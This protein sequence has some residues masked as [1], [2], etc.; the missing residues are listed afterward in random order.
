M[1]KR[2]LHARKLQQEGA[3][4]DAEAILRDVLQVDPCHVDALNLMGYVY[5]ARND[6]E[7]AELMMMRA[8]TFQ[9]R[10]PPN[11]ASL[12]DL[13]R[14]LGQEDLAIA[15]YRNGLEVDDTY[16]P[17]LRGLFMASLSSGKKAEAARV[18]GKLLELDPDDFQ[19]LHNVGAVNLSLAE[20]DLAI[21]NLSR[22]LEIK[23]DLSTREM[24]GRSY[25]LKG[26][27]E[28]AFRQYQ[29]ILEQDPNHAIAAHHLAANSGG[30]KSV[31]DRAADEYVR[32]AFD[33]F[34]KHFD[35]TLGD[36]RYQAPRIVRHMMDERLQEPA[37]QYDVLDLGCG[38]GLCGVE[39]APYCRTLIGIDLSEEMLKMAEQT[40]LYDAL[41]PA[42]LGSFLQ[43]DNRSFDCIVS[44]D[45]LV[46]LGELDH[47]F[48]AATG[49]LKPGGWL[50]ATLEAIEEDQSGPYQLKPSGRYAHSPAYLR[51]SLEKAGFGDIEL[52]EVHLRIE[53]GKPV[54]GF[55]M[56]AR[57][58]AA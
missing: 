4:D 29:L 31:P 38:T 34:A 54:E 15:C 44:A 26:D 52:M 19:T 45:T 43:E 32:Q 12:G 27:S 23:E 17:C 57:L 14:W 11:Y 47:V 50:V 25:S 35:K 40:Q 24:L 30:N 8:V 56:A 41:I 42:E 51:E 7:T 53:V 16:V 58:P 20:F 49:R 46:Y 55:A 18:G 9:P 28:N 10:H 1:H 21:G 37:K 39:I 2:L 36:L 6:A 22:A 5:Q 3:L 13:Y 33:D 48:A